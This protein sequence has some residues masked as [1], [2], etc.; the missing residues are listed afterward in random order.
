MSVIAW[1]AMHVAATRYNETHSADDARRYEEARAAYVREY[2][3]ALLTDD[4]AL[5]ELTEQHDR[6]IAA[7]REERGQ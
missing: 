5:R 1:N 2:A 4:P 7:Q 3:A 6:A